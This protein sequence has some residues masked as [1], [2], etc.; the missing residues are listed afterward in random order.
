MSF[1][2]IHI[3]K[4]RIFYQ[5]TIESTNRCYSNI[6]QSAWFEHTGS[7]PDIHLELQINVF[8]K[9]FIYI[10]YIFIIYFYKISKICTRQLLVIY[11][12]WI[13]NINMFEADNTTKI[14]PNWRGLS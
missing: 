8:Y 2:I 10:Y 11:K 9:I 13:K 14:I 7:N 12:Y 1:E 4:M 5:L 6:N 3:Y